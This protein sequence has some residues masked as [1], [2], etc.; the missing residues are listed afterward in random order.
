MKPKY[1][2]RHG[3]HREKGKEFSPSA[4]SSSTLMVR[5]DPVMALRGLCVISSM[6]KVSNGIIIWITA[7]TELLEFSCEACPGSLTA[8]AARWWRYIIAGASLSGRREREDRH[9]EADRGHAHAALFKFSRR[10]GKEKHSGKQHRVSEALA[11]NSAG[12]RRACTLLAAFAGRF[13]RPRASS[14]LVKDLARTDGVRLRIL[15]NGFA[16]SMRRK[17]SAD[18]RETFR[19]KSLS[20]SLPDCWAASSSMNMA[21]VNGCRL[22]PLQSQHPGAALQRIVSFSSRCFGASRPL[23]DRNTRRCR[24]S[25]APSTRPRLARPTLFSAA[26]GPAQPV[27]QKVFSTTAIF[28]SW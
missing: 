1:V 22:H 9:G 14:H 27:S 5:M 13:R 20:F 16:P 25:L 24:R 28:Y 26:W 18:R 4:F 19:I 6:L 23:I 3:G 12:G 21:R 15:T 10:G 17:L 2:S 11:G 7:L 8:G